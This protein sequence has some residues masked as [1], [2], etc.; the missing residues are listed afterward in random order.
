MTCAPGLTQSA[1]AL[2]TADWCTY[3][4]LFLNILLR[5]AVG[6]NMGIDC[7]KVD[8]KEILK[9]ITRRIRTSIEG[10]ME[11]DSAKARIDI[12]SRKVTRSKAEIQADQNGQNLVENQVEKGTKSARIWMIIR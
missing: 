7:K 9:K 8:K 4:S 3:T 6:L 1:Q 5:A 12:G 2:R 10:G 11:N